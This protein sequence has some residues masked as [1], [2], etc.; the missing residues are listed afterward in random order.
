VDDVALVIHADPPIEHKAYLHR[1]GRTARAGAEGTVVTLMT[2]DQVRDVRDLTKK[3]GIA[4]KVTKLRI[5]DPLLSELAPGERTF[6][7]PVAKTTIEPSAGRRTGGSASASGR[8]RRGRG[9]GPGAGAGRGSG[10]GAAR[11]AGTGAGRGTGG[12]RGAGQA[13]K[14]RGAARGGSGSSGAPKSYSTTT[15]GTGS[16][17]AGAAA[18]SAGTR[19]GGSRRGR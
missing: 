12:G 6:V 5:G 8:G 3:A 15:P 2:D 14:S 7:A 16:R 4:P 11:G 13:T 10:T 9:A 18:F 19:S 17:T 1:S